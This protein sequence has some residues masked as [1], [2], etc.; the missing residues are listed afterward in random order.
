M[1][2]WIVGSGF[3][4]AGSFAPL[5]WAGPSVPETYL[6]EPVVGSSS[7]VTL[8]ASPLEASTTV[9]R[10]LVAAHPLS[11]PAI[12]SPELPPVIPLPGAVLPGA[13]TLVGVFWSTRQRRTRK[14]A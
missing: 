3:L 10:S 12:P 4:M 11:A 9:E 6:S 13:V 1:R 7:T 5:A 2:R 14:S 8:P